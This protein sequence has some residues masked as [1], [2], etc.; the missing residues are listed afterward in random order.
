MT[1]APRRWLTIQL[2]RFGDVFQTAPVIASFPRDVE[3]DLLVDSSQAEAAGLLP[4]VRRVLPVARSEALRMI[5]NEDLSR[6][7]RFWGDLKAELGSYGYDRVVNL[8]HTPESAL[9]ARLAGARE[10]RGALYDR[11]GM[12][13][14]DSWERLFRAV[15]TRRDWGGFHLADY[16]RMSAGGDFPPVY[17][18]SST[19]KDRFGV[20][21]LQLGANS[22]LRMWPVA[23][24]AQTA[25]IVHQRTKVRFVVLGTRGEEALASEFARL[26]AVPFENLVG[27][28]TP[29]QLAGILR[30]CDLLLSGDTGTIH[31]AALMGVQTVGVYLGTARPDDTA[32]WREGA[33]VFEPATICCPCPENHHCL[34]LSCHND[35]P[36]EAVAET[37]LRLLRGE[38]V[39]PLDG[40]SWRRRL[41]SFNDAGFPT[42]TG[43]KTT[44]SGQR[45][46]AMKALWMS[47]FA[48]GTDQ[49]ENIQLEPDE[50]ENLIQ[51][52]A[53][54]SEGAATARRLREDLMSNVAGRERPEI[55]RD[56]LNRVESFTTGKG[57]AGLLTQMASLELER[58]PKGAVSSAGLIEKVLASLTR[59]IQFC[60]EAGGVRA[61]ARGAA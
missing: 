53:L 26:A 21:A 29:A 54:A 47:E 37:I 56:T 33:V 27:R 1:D 34:H 45:R 11:K 30:G 58:P 25:A 40:Q 4:N 31:L 16:H 24:F 17:S 44:T 59:R 15:I 18:P 20:I 55:L 7:S 48:G 10:Y 14:A 57:L 49:P 19:T 41:V 2:A 36:P 3:T 9:I 38:R 5:L 12:F 42:L 43:E 51:L 35:L 8:T 50:R 60:A 52:G 6:S 28:T 39:Y 13:A 23:S 46:A 61:V 22:L 32:P